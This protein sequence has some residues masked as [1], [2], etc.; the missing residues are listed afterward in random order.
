[1]SKDP[2]VGGYPFPY[3]FHRGIRSCIGWL[4]RF[5]SG[6]FYFLHVHAL[7][8]PQ[9]AT[10]APPFLLDTLSRFLFYQSKEN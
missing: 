7:Y 2:L 4:Y 10:I 8:N 9:G 1:M 3:G 5:F 6:R